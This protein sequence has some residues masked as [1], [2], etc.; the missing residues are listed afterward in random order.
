MPSRQ[1][2]DNFLAQKNIAIVGVS[3]DD[4]QLANMIF[5]RLRDEGHNVYAVNPHADTLEGVTAYHR[6]ADIPDP[7]DGVMIVL[8]ADDAKE[9]VS[10][11]IDRG[12]S[13]IWLHHGFGPSAVSPEALAMCAEHG[14]EVVDGACAFMYD[15]PVRGPHRVHRMLTHN[16]A[17]A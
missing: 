3:R 16:R 7:L 4:K 15:K 2:I 10:E 17:R 12:V 14:V 1:A 9:V 5:R 13:R 6:I 11:A 8:R